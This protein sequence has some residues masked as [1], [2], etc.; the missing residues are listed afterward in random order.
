MKN[1]LPTVILTIMFIISMAGASWSMNYKGNIEGYSASDYVKPVPTTTGPA[2]SPITS[3]ATIHDEPDMTV[4]FS[5]GSLYEGYGG[6]IDVFANNIGNFNL[7]LNRIAFEWTDT[8]HRF[9][10]DVFLMIPRGETVNVGILAITGPDTSGLTNYRISVDVLQHRAGTWVQLMD[11]NSNWIRFE[12]DALHVDPLGSAS[13]YSYSVNEKAY[14]DRVNTLVTLESASVENVAAYATVPLGI[15]Y[16]VDKLCAIFDFVLSNISYDLE[17][18]GEDI[19]QSPEE[20]LST[21]S[22]DCEDFSMLIAAMVREIG[23]TPR[24][25]LIDGH[26]FAAVYIGN[27]SEDFQ[28]V[29]QSIVSWYDTH[30]EVHAIRDDM[31]YWV[32]ADPLGSFHFGGLSV[33]AV[34]TEF[35]A[36]W[37]WTFNETSAV[38][39]IDVTARPSS[40]LFLYKPLFWLGI[41][42]LFGILLIGNL[43][44]KPA[45]KPAG[46]EPDEDQILAYPD[47][48]EGLP[49]PPPIPPQAP[50]E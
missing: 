43:L 10:K 17:Q 39:G 47:E 28:N 3:T 11:G 42:F 12:P 33:S 14:Y 19:W 40:Q 13:T 7:F 50:P 36:G 31:G 8:G 34:P 20:C 5:V 18:E 6:A 15:G 16:G 9:E 35:N 2:H 41:V 45:E 4:Q 29:S 30:V 38:I 46:H 26:A 1:R 32:I 27:N 24:M 21:K 23:G 49:P 25:Y 44:S 37:D 48:Q 22:G